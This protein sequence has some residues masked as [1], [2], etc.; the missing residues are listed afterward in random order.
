MITVKYTKDGQNYTKRV[1]TFAHTQTIGFLERAGYVITDNGLPQAPAAPEAPAAPAAPAQQTGRVGNGKAVHV[2][3]EGHARCGAS[4]RK[5][6]S[7]HT[8]RKVHLTGE[9]VTCRNCH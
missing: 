5:G 1:H 6:H 2:I 8:T 9:A 4:W 3:V 7:F